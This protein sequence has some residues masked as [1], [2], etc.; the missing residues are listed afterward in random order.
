[1]DHF[2]DIQ[3]EEMYSS[4]FVEEIYEEIFDE[5]EDERSFYRFLNSNYEH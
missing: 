4:D 5:D 2:D 1:M 3:I